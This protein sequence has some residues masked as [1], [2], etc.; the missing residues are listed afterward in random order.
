MMRHLS[1]KTSISSTSVAILK[2]SAGV[3]PS[4]VVFDLDARHKPL[5]SRQFGQIDPLRRARVTRN[6]SDSS[7][8]HGDLLFDIMSLI[9]K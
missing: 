2:A 7:D 4:L 9:G 8:E 3:A 1:R 5:G 6:A